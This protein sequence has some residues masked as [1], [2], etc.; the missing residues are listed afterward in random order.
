MHRWALV[1]AI[2]VQAGMGQSNAAAA[3]TS[4]PDSAQALGTAE[5]PV[6]A[7][8][9]RGQREYL[10]RLRCPSGE[11]PVFERLGSYGP[12]ADGHLLDGYEVQCGSGAPVMVFMDMYHS[13]YR[14]LRPVRGFAVL[15]DI[16]ARVAQG[17][18]PQVVAEPDSA[19]RYAFNELEVEQPVRL[20]ENFSVSTPVEV[21]IRGQAHLE[22]VIDTAGQPE[23][24]TLRA[25]Y[26]SDEQLRP[27]LATAVQRIPLLPAEHRPG[28]RV[29]QR[30]DFHLNFQ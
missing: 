25:L 12:G 20:R 9:P 3:Q 7:A 21:G 28:C 14:E 4:V 10:S 17:C 26:V 29:R 22:V 19:A 24:E 13:N 6:R 16:P 1:A 30:V 11:A 5:M 2:S 18:P 15:S 27:H 8:G 23:V